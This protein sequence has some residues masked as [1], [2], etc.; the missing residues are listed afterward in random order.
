MLK[1]GLQLWP[2]ASS[3]PSL[4][5]SAIRAEAACW[6]SLW[7]ADHLLGSQN[8]RLP[9]LEGWTTMPGWLRSRDGCRLGGL[10]RRTPC[11]TRD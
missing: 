6:E 2:N 3:W 10:C 5:A 7:T 11:A 1:V 4:R 8:P 9:T